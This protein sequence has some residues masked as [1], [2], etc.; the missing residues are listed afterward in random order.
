MLPQISI[1]NTDFDRLLNE[2]RNM[3]P[4]VYEGWTD[5]NPSDPGITL[6]ELFIWLMEN[7]SYMMDR[8]T[9]DDMKALFK[10]YGFSER[11]SVCAASKLQLSSKESCIIKPGEAFYAGGLCFE[12]GK[13]REIREERIESLKN[14][15]GEE[16]NINL[17]A[18]STRM[19]YEPFGDRPKK[20]DAFFIFFRSAPLKGETIHIYAEIE[21]RGPKPRKPLLDGYVPVAEIGLRQE[22]EAIVSLKDG[23]KGFTESGELIL[24]FN[25][26]LPKRKLQGKE[27]Y[28][29]EIRLKDGGYEY[30]PNILSI[31]TNVIDILQKE[32]LCTCERL[33]LEKLGEER[34]GIYPKNKHF[35]TG[36][37]EVY[38]S[39]GDD[40]YQ[41][42]ESAHRAFDEAGRLCISFPE[43]DI[44][45][46]VLRVMAVAVSP[47][48]LEDRRIGFA[49][50]YDAQEFPLPF[51]QPVTEGMELLSYNNEN[52]SYEVWKIAESFY[53][54]GP[55]SRVFIYD[56]DKKKLCFGNGIH[57]R[58]P[59]GW[60]LLSSFTRTEGTAGN[61]RGGLVTKAEDGGLRILKSE[62]SLGGMDAEDVKAALSRLQKELSTP[63]RAV[64]REDYRRLTEETPGLM[65]EAVAVLDEKELAEIG[66]GTIPNG[67][68][69][70]AKPYVDPKQ[71]TIAVRSIFERAYR[72]NILKFL[73]PRRLINTDLR[74]FMARIISVNV[75]IDLEP[76]PG[77]GDCRE[78]VERYVEDWFYE[79]GKHFGGILKRSELFALVAALDSVKTMIRLSFDVNGSEAT[80]LSGGNLQ[81]GPDGSV[82]LGRLELMIRK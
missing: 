41:R 54:Y 42:I 37:I 3:I 59:E 32:T 45:K 9:Q 21:K 44:P 38:A 77:H 1:D 78:N 16:F 8:L 36:V 23:T 66:G 64:T 68:G 35:E 49:L 46:E 60:L 5:L 51:S 26:D 50:G 15:L 40:I 12:T 30:P 65:L 53:N 71:D 27:G 56:A 75:Y 20:G 31:S 17:D 19:A 52:E 18:G 72:Y 55:D 70:V 73:E 6:L 7:Q 48:F 81:I 58:M 4:V 39:S 11:A 28:F 67:I 14:S 62:E 57:G 2:Y 22:D 25:A 33:N 61:I 63:L 43:K 74:V 29:L 69:I 13:E 76:M 10:L 82:E 47:G 24:E 79:R 34:L 80:K